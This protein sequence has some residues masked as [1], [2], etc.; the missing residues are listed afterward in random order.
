MR[1]LVAFLPLLVTVASAAGQGG[2]RPQVSGIYP[3][4][5]MFNDEGECGTG[6]VVPWAG[7]LWVVTYAPHEPRGSSDKLY[8]IDADL[9]QAIRAESIGGTPANRLI[10]RESQQLFLGPYVIDR[11]G[12]VRVIPYA[13]MFGRHTGTARH[14]TD[15]AKK[16][17]TATMEEGLYEIDVDTLA[18]TELWADEQQKEGRHA[19]LPGYHGKGLYSGQGRLVYA[20]NG[21]HGQRALRD[22]TTPSG[23]LA[24]WDGQ[25]D[26]WTVVRRNQFTEVT[27]PGGIHGNAD[28]KRDPIWSV[29]W[30]HRSLILQVLHDGRW[31]TYRLPKG[32]HS[33]DGAHGWNTEWPRIRDIGEDDLLMT[34]HGLFWR[35]PR[36]FRPGATGGLAP[37]S[38][39][40]KV[41]GDFC[42]FGD[43]V[44]FG[45]DD[46]AKNEFLNQRKA[47]GEI[48]A[49]RSQSNL[50]FVEPERI[51]RLGPVRA[52]GSPWAHEDVAAGAVTAPFLVGGFA[53]RGLH[54]AHRGDRSVEVRVEVDVAGDGRF[55][56]LATVE[57]QPRG[58]RWLA[59]TAPATWLRLRAPRPIRSAVA[60][61]H[62]ASADG[63]TAARDPMFDALAGVGADD[64]IGGLVR[65]RGGNETTMAFAVQTPGVDEPV[66]DVGC[67]EL[68]GALELAP[69]AD[70]GLHRHT[71]EHTAIPL[72]VL[73]GDAASL[74]FVDEA[75]RRWRLPRLPERTAPAGDPGPFTLAVAGRV[76]REVA[77][78]RD[79]FHALGTFYEL[80]ATNAGGFAKVRPVASHDRF[81]QDFCS[82]RGLLVMTGVAVDAPAGEHVVRSADGRA[83]LWVGA[84][85]DLWRLGKPR[86][87]GGPWLDTP[88]A[89]GAVSDPY[90]VTGYDRK[91]LTLRHDADR[92]VRMTV[93][94]DLCGDGRWTPVRTFEVPTGTPRIHEFDR[95]W[96]AYWL[97]VRA[98]RACSATAQLR[99]R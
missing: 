22:P 85:D 2:S 15:P 97:R 66:A 71:L 54:L 1:L 48:A 87:I 99:Y 49:P 7:R 21:E 16:V 6:A 37:R 79:L 70:A 46:T 80:P 62:L 14:L 98:E 24:E 94:A 3:H 74:V 65:A 51:D 8:T 86:G 19:D 55:V 17:Y 77:T 50:W 67:Y 31:H 43:R 25:A 69:T 28:P 26:R 34:M 84:I 92:P 12:D 9:T 59:L 13:E 75:G 76:A 83:A 42:R 20:N 52:V 47:K 56:E 30:D 29:G 95:A 45:C 38:A 32:S 40:L 73:D 23:V 63:R 78:E 91:E 53:R 41:I 39:Y 72:G 82:F 5:A 18:V 10:H 89:A 93:E 81:V 44:V 35:F 57:L 4:L 90:L 68:D 60:A 61:L 58:Y 33:Y 27:G 88:V 11:R 96:S 36:A 64:C